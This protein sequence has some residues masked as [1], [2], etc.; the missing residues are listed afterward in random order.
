LLRKPCF[1]FAKMS[2]SWSSA[3]A[4]LILIF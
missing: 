1:S 2:H 3:L 4:I